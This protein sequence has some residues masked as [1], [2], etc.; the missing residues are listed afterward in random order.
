MIFSGFPCIGKSTVTNNHKGSGVIDLE[1]SMLFVDGKRPDNW[2]KIYINYAE[3]LNK[4][5]YDVFVS[6]H[7]NVREELDSRGVDY[8]SIFPS[9]ELKGEWERKLKARYEA[10]PTEKNKRAMDYILGHFDESVD[11]MQ[12]DKHPCRLVDKD[13]MLIKVLTNIHKGVEFYGSL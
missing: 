4:Q 11:D 5:G 3:D 6:S 7:K 13:Y 10:E 9:K 12:N 8:V 1:S 2:E